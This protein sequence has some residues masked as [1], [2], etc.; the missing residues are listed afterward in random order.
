MK[1]IKLIATSIC[2][3]AMT[4]S[5]WAADWTYFCDHW[6]FPQAVLD[7]RSQL[8]SS[9]QCDV[10]EVAGSPKCT[11]NCELSE[12]IGDACGMKYNWDVPEND[13]EYGQV[14][15]RPDCYGCRIDYATTIIL[16][17]STQT[18]ACVERNPADTTTSLY[19]RGCECPPL[20]LNNI[21]PMN[22][23]GHPHE[24]VHDYQCC[25]GS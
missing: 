20:D 18:L 25:S 19:I 6:F 23:D 9:L 10:E 11:G 4:A 8:D 15:P 5:L 16:I 12:L 2:V 21:V 14:V 3:A 17:R 22:E 13:P 1:H 7:D 24:D